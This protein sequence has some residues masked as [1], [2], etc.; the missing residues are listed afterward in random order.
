MIDAYT[1]THKEG[2]KRIAAWLTGRKRMAVVMA[3][4]VVT[5]VSETPDVIAWSGRGESI[6][7]EVKVS[8]ADFHADKA[9]I[10]RREEDYGVGTQRYFAA[11]AGVLKPEDMPEGWG[12]LAIHQYQVRELVAPTIKTANRVNEVAMLVSA[13]RRLELSAT[14]FVRHEEPASTCD[15][16][17]A[18]DGP[19]VCGHCQQPREGDG[20]AKACPVGWRCAHLSQEQ[21]EAM[22]SAAL[23]QPAGGEKR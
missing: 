12:L 15:A 11:P 19:K 10:F 17:V 7:V 22:R 2:V 3:E 20:P 21:S 8:R 9:K 4:R 5:A 18:A 13:I 6:L 23:D 14:V 16:G 1:C